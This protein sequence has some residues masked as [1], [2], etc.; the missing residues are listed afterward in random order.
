MTLLTTAETRAALERQVDPAGHPAADGTGWQQP[1]GMHWRTFERLTARQD[2]F[3]GVSLAGMEEL[4]DLM[5][6]R[7]HGLRDDLNGEG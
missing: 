6:R 4:L 7:L 2:A 3:V 5:N 1:K